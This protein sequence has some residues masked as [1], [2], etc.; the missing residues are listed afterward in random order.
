MKRVSNLRP[1]PSKP[2]YV[3]GTFLGV[4]VNPIRKDALLSSSKL[5]CTGDYATPINPHR[6]RKA[7]VIFQSQRFRRQL[8]AAIE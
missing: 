2:I 1:E 3:S 5:T 8:R 4:S 7:V 6:E